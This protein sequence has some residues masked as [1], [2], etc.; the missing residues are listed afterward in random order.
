M[1]IVL[2]LIVNWLAVGFVTAAA[3]GMMAGGQI[4]WHPDHEVLDADLDDAG[5][6]PTLEELAVQTGWHIYLEPTAG[7]SFTTQFQGLERGPAMRSLLGDLN[8]MFVPEATGPTRLFI[9]QTSREAATVEIGAKPAPK[10]RSPKAAIV[11][12]QLIVRLKAGARIEEIA[13]RLGARVKGRIGDMN[14][15]LLEFENADE[16]ESARSKLASSEEVESVENNY[17]VERPSTLQP[18]SGS[19]P[20]PIQL[21]LNP[22]ATGGRIVV[23]LIDTSMQ[24][25]GNGLDQFLLPAISVAGEAPAAEGMTHEP[26]MA[27]TILRAL[28]TATAGNTDV[29]I[30]PVDVYG[31]NLTAST[32]DVAAGIIRAVNNTPSP[33]ILNL[34]LGSYNNSAILS[35]AIQQVTALGVVVFAAAGNDPVSQPFFPAALPGVISVTASK[36]PGELASY[37]NYAPSVDMMA[38]GSSVVYLDGKAYMVTGTSAASAYAAGLAAGLADSHGLTVQ[39]AA[40][41]VQNALPA[42]VADS[43]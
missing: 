18:V 2:K 31:P 8:Y 15:Y 35:S 34:S 22:G 30:L 40:E 24:P 16:L 1:R 7:K 28:Q 4:T 20:P 27:Q 38:P 19:L 29:R 41:S 12:N 25:L 36:S 32:F 11:P 39:E 10:E 42:P 17:Y 14:A 43:K 26:A 33:T 13:A 5:L 3:A 6:I 37:A 23:G 21:K 9:F